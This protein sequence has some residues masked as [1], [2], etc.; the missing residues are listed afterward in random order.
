MKRNLC[1][2]KRNSFVVKQQTLDLKDTSLIR[3]IKLT[4]ARFS[5]KFS[6]PA[7]GNSQIFKGLSSFVWLQVSKT[8][9]YF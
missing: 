2:D 8:L 1:G 7:K 3:T 4:A 5:K 6:S 9:K